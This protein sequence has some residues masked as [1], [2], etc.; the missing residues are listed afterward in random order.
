VVLVSRLVVALSE[1]VSSGVGL[2]VAEALRRR[3]LRPTAT[4]AGR[5]WGR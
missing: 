5:T 4:L 1:L 3:Q 2:A